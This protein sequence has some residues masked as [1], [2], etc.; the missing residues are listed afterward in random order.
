MADLLSREVKYL[1]GVGEARARLLEREVGV[2]TIGD[3]LGRFPYRYI[4]R[5]R[6]FAIKDIDETLESTYVQLRCRVVGKSIV[7]E[8]A[9]ARFTVEVCDPTGVA[10]L[11]W[12]RGVKWIEKRIELQREYMVFGRFPRRV[13]R[14]QGQMPQTVCR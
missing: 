14:L 9:K 11:T 6:L 3:L 2:R 12:F 4:D 5:S 8:G 7:G 1:S 10:E 13:P